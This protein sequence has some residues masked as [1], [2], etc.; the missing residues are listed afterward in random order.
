MGK[1][2]LFY[3]NITFYKW[4]MWPRKID[5]THSSVMLISCQNITFSYSIFRDLYIENTDIALGQG[6]SAIEF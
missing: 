2:K 4:E 1:V 3:L 5:K 6:Y